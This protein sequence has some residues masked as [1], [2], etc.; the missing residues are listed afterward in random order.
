MSDFDAAYGFRT[1]SLR[2]FNAAG[3]D[4]DGDIGEAHQPETHLIPLAIHAA[5]DSEYR[6]SIFGTDYDTPD[7]T[8]VRDYVHVTDLADAHLRALKYLTAG[9]DSTSLNLG[10][11]RGHSVRDVVT[12]VSA[13]TGREVKI[14][15][16][17]R[18]PG[19]PP[20]LVS[21]SSQARLLLGW[22]S[23]LSDLNQIVR[24]AAAWHSKAPIATS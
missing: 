24:T 17:K 14:T 22:R 20:N 16:M 12:E 2:Y 5:N 19:D 4:P 10:T 18:R 7:G 9:G 3:A 11:E 1:V 15:E 8:A 23:P 6:L 21:D 13:A